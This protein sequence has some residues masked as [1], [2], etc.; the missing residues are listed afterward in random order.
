MD[1]EWRELELLV[2]KIERT[3][4]PTGCVIKSPDHI[5]D[6]VTGEEREVDISIRGKLGSA[7]TLIIIECRNRNKLQDVR[8]IEEISTKRSDLLASK[9]IAVSKS[10]F[11]QQAIDKARHHGIDL[12]TF[13]EITDSDIS[14]WNKGLIVTLLSVKYRVISIT[15]H[16]KS[17]T[18]NLLTL[19]DAEA[20]ASDPYKTTVAYRQGI[21]VVLEQLIDC[22]SLAEHLADKEGV[23]RVNQY[24]KFSDPFTMH[25]NLGVLELDG[26]SAVLD[27]WKEQHVISADSILKY[28]DTLAAKV[29]ELA[30]YDGSPLGFDNIRM[31]AHRIID[32]K[33]GDPPATNS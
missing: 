10:G 13:D 3:L 28:R 23:Q 4:S 32:E 22:K 11:S 16:F 9:A 26:F 6:K 12:R 17:G 25:T 15:H 20:W 2:E 29:Y 19:L 5:I 1:K 31:T 14:D 24:L 33:S 7:D 18:A 30:D 8:W 21:P 27:T